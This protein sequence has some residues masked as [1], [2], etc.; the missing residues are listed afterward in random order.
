M[1]V[2]ALPFIGEL[3]LLSWFCCNCPTRNYL[4]TVVFNSS[5]IFGLLCY[6][7]LGCLLFLDFVSVTKICA[8]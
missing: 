1:S 4:L 5:S 8:L 6:D 3:A 7:A 2:G